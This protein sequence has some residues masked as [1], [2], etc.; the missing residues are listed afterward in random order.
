MRTSTLLSLP[1]AI[2]MCCATT[3][4]PAAPLPGREV[5]INTERFAKLAPVEQDEVLALQV[6]LEELIATDRSTLTPNE[7][8]ALRTE[9]KQLKHEMR[10]HNDGGHGNVIYLST[11]GLIIIILL[12]II[13]L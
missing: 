6:R 8:A 5:H 1:F 10:A 13:L 9:W 12:L 3:S 2:T 7:R 11:A 4:V